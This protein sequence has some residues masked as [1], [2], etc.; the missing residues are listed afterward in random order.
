M[1]TH[2]QIPLLLAKSALT[3]WVLTH[4]TNYKTNFLS[5]SQYIRIEN[6]FISNLKR[7]ACAS[8]REGLLLATVQYLIWYQIFWQGLL[9]N[10][11]AFV[12]Q[13]VCP[14]RV[15]FLFLAHLKFMNAPLLVS[16]VSTAC[17]FSLTSFGLH[18]SHFV[19]DQ[20][21]EQATR[22]YFSLK[23]IMAMHLRVI[24]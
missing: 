13:S 10:V 3:C 24:Y 14:F 21:I 6:L 15:F 11:N 5:K 22:I 16:F 12:G 17:F 2:Q 19:W 8:K 4:V 18:P 7:P 23:G 9:S 20:S 1:L